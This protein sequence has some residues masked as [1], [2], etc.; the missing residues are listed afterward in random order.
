MHIQKNIIRIGIM[1]MLVLTLLGCGIRGSGWET[2][3][4]ILNHGWSPERME[5]V[6]GEETAVKCMTL[7]DIRK[8]NIWTELMKAN[9]EVGR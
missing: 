6:D 7:E 3:P 8:I 9:E 1:A 2:P 4:P 5:I